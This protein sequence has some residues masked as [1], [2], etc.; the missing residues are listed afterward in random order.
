MRFTTEETEEFLRRMFRAPVDELTAALLG[1]KTE[2]W[3]TG[4][5][6]AALSPRN[7]EDL[8]RA[9]WELKERFYNISQYFVSE[10]L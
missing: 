2:G 3:V 4:L 8:E 7:Q 1:E 9:I 5:R 6:L 10:V